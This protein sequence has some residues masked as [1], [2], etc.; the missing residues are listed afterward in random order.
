VIKIFVMPSHGENS[1]SSPSGAPPQI[2]P[3]YIWS[4]VSIICDRR[5]IAKRRS[6]LQQ[7]SDKSSTPVKAYFFFQARVLSNLIVGRRSEY[8]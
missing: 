2:K 6:R 7:R 3:N 1:G 4:F 8:L 5:F